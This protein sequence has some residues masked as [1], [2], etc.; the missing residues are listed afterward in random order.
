MGYANCASVG[1]AINKEIFCII[2]D[3]SI[4]MNSQNYLIKTI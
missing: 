4:P 3:G 2:G 1:A